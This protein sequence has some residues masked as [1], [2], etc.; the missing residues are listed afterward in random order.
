VTLRRQDET[1][2]GK[3]AY[4]P[5]SDRAL[6]AKLEQAV[7]DSDQGIPD[8]SRSTLPGFQPKVLVADIDG[9]WAYPHARAHSTYILEPQVPARP[10]RVLDEHYSHLLSRH[11]GLSQYASEVRKAGRTTYLAIERFDRELVDGTVLLRSNGSSPR[12]SRGASSAKTAQRW[13]SARLSRHCATR[14]APSSHPKA[15]R[16]AS[17]SAFSGTCDGS[18]PGPR[19]AMQ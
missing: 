7:N 8:D 14:S 16:R 5:L 1:S 13:S 9:Q 4:E 17:Q 2:T 10:G 3:P 19:S 12:R 6:E 18:S 11:M 15:Y